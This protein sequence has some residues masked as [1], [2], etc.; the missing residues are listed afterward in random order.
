MSLDEQL[1]WI[2]RLTRRPADLAELEDLAPEDRR[3]LETIDPDR[4]RAV[5]RTQALLT[6]ERWWRARFPAVLATL[7][8]LYGGPAEAAS[9]LVSS[10]AFEAAQGE[11]ETGAAFVGALF[12]LS[13]DPDWRGPDWIFDLLGYEYLLSTGLPRRA[14][15]EPVD[16][17]LEARLLPHARW[18]AGGRLRRPALVVSFAW[19]VGALA[20]QPHDADPDPHDLVFLLGP[21]DAV[22]LSGDG[23][24][25]AVELLASG[26]NDDVLE[27]GLGPSAPTVL[28][29]LRAEGAY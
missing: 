8:H 24:A 16:E 12:D 7:E 29:H 6:V 26:A 3:V 9:R 20:T 18:Y 22:E 21:Q 14:R 23:F 28:A 17:D 27:E 25:D 2:E 1:R 15:H 5:H 13:A 19:P 10:P 11:D 4:L